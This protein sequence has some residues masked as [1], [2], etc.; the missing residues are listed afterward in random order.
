MLAFPAFSALSPDHSLTAVDAAIAA[1][2]QLLEQLILVHLQMAA[3]RQHLAE[4]VMLT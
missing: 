1:N 2:Q 3:V 4:I